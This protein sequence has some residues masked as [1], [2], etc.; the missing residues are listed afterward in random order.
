MRKIENI[1]KGVSIKPLFQKLKES[2][3][4]HAMQNISQ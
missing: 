2:K 3:H 4:E 1:K